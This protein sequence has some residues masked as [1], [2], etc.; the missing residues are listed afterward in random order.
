LLERVDRVLLAVRDRD[1]AAATFAAVLGA[2][3]ARR[4]EVPVYN[5]A[6]TVVQAGESEFE[7]L[8]PGGPGAVADHLE[9]WGE[10][11]FAAGF[12]TSDVPG[13]ARLLFDAGLH[14]T[15]ETNQLFLEPDQTRGMRTV[16][17]NFIERERVG[18][19]TWLYEVTNIVEDHE[20]AAQFYSRIFGLD[21]ARFSP[22]ESRQYGY[23]GT[24]T[25]FNP[26]ER[27]DRIELT[28]ITDPQGAMGRF[29]SRRGPSIYMCFVE[30]EDVRSIQEALDA[31]GARYT[32]EQHG[33]T[34]G[35]MFIH[36]RALHGM[37][38][39]I[40]RTNLA[41][42]WSGRPELAGE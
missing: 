21:A 29:F 22:I 37:L 25:L 31:R 7:L 11:I 33:T 20:E 32:G 14:F 39:G 4:D 34:P 18:R 8:E 10:G 5:A 35:E 38:M 23:K 2:E 40:S 9:Q 1:Q 42:R 24:L 28:Q 3:E 19:I 36:P 30:T 15:E 16:I 27:L 13:V 6:R 12:S 26:P 17:S 41:W